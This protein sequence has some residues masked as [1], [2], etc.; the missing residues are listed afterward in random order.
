MNVF[1]LNIINLHHSSKAS[2]AG[3]ERI[4]TGLYDTVM[5]LFSLS[6]FF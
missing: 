3:D 5:S 6:L 4:L 1:T 2:A